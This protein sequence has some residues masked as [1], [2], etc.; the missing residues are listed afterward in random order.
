MRVKINRNVCG[1][2]LAFCER[3]LGQFWYPGMNVTASKN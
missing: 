3:C 1:A 2:H